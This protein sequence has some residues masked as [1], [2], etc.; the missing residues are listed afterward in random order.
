MAN[1]DFS[2]IKV[3]GGE[4]TPSNFNKLCDIVQSQGISTGPGYNIK[5]S[6]GGTTLSINSRSNAVVPPPF[7]VTITPMG[8]TDESTV[9][10][11]PGTVNQLLPSD[12][13]TTFTVDNS[14]TYYVKAIAST[15]GKNVTSVSLECDTDVPE[16]QTATPF[17]L[18]TTVEIPL[19]VISDGSLFRLIGTGSV[20]LAGNQVF[21]TDKDPPAD[22]GTLPYTPW[23]IWS[24]VNSPV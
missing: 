23:F 19:Y 15:D 1:I 24:V 5:R 4:V 2:Q 18:P 20:S 8:T 12:T 7:L 11:Y 13:Y 17:G 3:W 9:V 10:L 21:V 14:G 16:A 22:P 6:A